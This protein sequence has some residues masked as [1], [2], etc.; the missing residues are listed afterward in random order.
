ML[1]VAPKGDIASAM[2]IEPEEDRLLRSA[3]GRYGGRAAARAAAAPVVGHYQQL[4]GGQWFLC[5][6]R[7]EAERPPA[8]VPV[9][10]TH[11]RRHEDARWPVHC[12]TCDFYR[13]PDEQRVI[14][15]SYAPPAVSEPLR[16]ARPLGRAAAAAP[17]RLIEARTHDTTRPGIARLLVQLVTGAGLQ[18]I[19]PH[20]RPSPLIDQVKAIW[21]AARAIEIDAGVHLPEFL[22]T[23]PARLGDLIARLEAASPK[24]FT[25]TR[26]HGV[27]IIR[28]AAIGG[29]T[30]Q[31]VAGD[32]IPVRG[33]L[34]VFGE[35]AGG[36]R[37]T[38]AE[39]SARAPYLVACVVGRALQGGPVEVLSAYA[40]PCVSETHLML[41]D[42]DMERRTLHQ[43]RSVQRWLGGKRHL[44]VTIEKPMFDIGPA[45]QHGAEPRPP[46]M[47]DFV[48][49]S[50]RAGGA[51]MPVIAETM[52]FAGE[53]YRVRKKRVH[54]LMAAALG[55]APVIEH[56]FHLP[57]DVVQDRRDTAFW[58]AIRWALGGPEAPDRS[59][60]ARQVQPGRVRPASFRGV[61]SP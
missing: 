31:P 28:A 43:L 27:L 59:N 8:L 30:L 13:E 45:P 33:R 47:P 9:S 29:G 50:Q 25:R 32:P 15:G 14:T 11:I 3:F 17:E 22:C 56:D 39:R 10:Q 40:H 4:R 19:E 57:V 52:G 41:V 2:L 12:D 24:R 35:R 51:T 16:L 61:S 44:L 46:C 49:R 23:S 26:P 37:E 7:P 20:W 34:A 48:L 42:S 58:Q 36:G 60:F 1:R 5:G 53:E 54:P 55:G 18:V 21:A 38:R 6:C